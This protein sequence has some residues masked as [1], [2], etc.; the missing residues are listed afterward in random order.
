MRHIFLLFLFVLLAFGSSFHVLA[1]DAATPNPKTNYFVNGELVKPWRLVVG[2]Q[3]NWFT[4]IDG[5]FGDTVGGNLQ[6]TPSSYLAQDVAFNVKWSGRRGPAAFSLNSEKTINL[7]Q[8]ED[9]AA[10]AIKMRIKR[11]PQ[12]GLTLRMDCEWPCTGPVQIRELL[13]RYKKDEW[14][15]FPMPLNCFSKAGTDLSNVNT[16]LHMQTSGKAEITIAKVSLV[17]LPKDYKGCN[18]GG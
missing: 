18:S 5:L 11:H 10:L 17:P 9:R 7:S 1:K 16:I 15:I 6:I 13:K 12:R 14:F 4:P 2:N 8:L 3:K